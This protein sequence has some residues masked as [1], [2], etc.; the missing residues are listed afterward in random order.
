MKILILTQKVDRN[1]DILGFFHQWIIAFA[2]TYEHVTVLCLEKGEYDLPQTVTIHSLGK[3]RNS[4]FKRSRYVLNFYRFLWRTRH[5][6]DAVFIH[7]NPEYVVLGG[8]LWRV[9]GKR[10]AL[11]YNH[12]EG[13]IFARFGAFFAHHIFYTSPYAFMARF[14]KA[15]KMSA[16]IDTTRKSDFGEGVRSQT[17]DILSLGRISPVKHIEVIIEALKKLHEKGIVFT[18]NIYGNPTSRD[19]LYYQDIKNK[20]RA[21]LKKGLLFFHSAIPN[22]ETPA[23]FSA[24]RVFVN[25]TPSGSLDKTILEAVY[26]GA[27]PVVCNESF[28]GFLTDEF[29][30]IEGD[31]VDLAEKLAYALTLSLEEREALGR[32]L[33]EK[34]KKEHSLEKLI[35]EITAIL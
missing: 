28:R 32:R 9:W 6:Y 4:F 7:M 21:L 18:A 20:A 10:V 19:T 27:L 25:A 16:G 34:V 33:Q 15:R 14:K 3:E 35:K 31:S 13:G 2:N 12:K 5:D 24:H 17:S 30:F 11:W 8:L 26:H 22:H 29:F 23:I 1:D